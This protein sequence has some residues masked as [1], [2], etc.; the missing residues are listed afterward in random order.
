MKLGLSKPIWKPN[1]L[2]EPNQ[3]Q[4]NAGRPNYSNSRR[5][6]F[7]TKNRLNGLVSVSLPP[8]PKKPKKAK[9]MGEKPIF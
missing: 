1:P 6:V 8:K 4:S 7:S 5:R 9:P 3:N 2:G